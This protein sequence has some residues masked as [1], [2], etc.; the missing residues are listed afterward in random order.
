MADRPAHWSKRL[1]GLSPT[2]PEPSPR[3]HSSNSTSGFQP[4]AV[5]S[6]EIDPPVGVIDSK[7]RPGTS[8]ELERN[9]PVLSRVLFQSEDN[10][11]VEELCE[12]ISS[13]NYP[14]PPNYPVILL[15]I[16]TLNNKPSSPV[17]YRSFP[18]MTTI[19]S[20]ASTTSAMSIQ[21]LVSV[22]GGGTISIPFVTP[23]TAIFCSTSIPS[24]S[25]SSQAI[26]S[27]IGFFP[28]GMPTNAIPSVP[29]SIPSAT[30]TSMASGSNYFHGFP[31]RGGHIPHSNP[32]LGSC[33]FPLRVK[34]IICFKVGKTLRLVG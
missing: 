29:L 5:G 25:R 7:G 6:S 15:Y 23:S 10:I 19:G 12:S 17:L 33:L 30:S 32:T 18:S 14:I 27:S 3:R 13:P 1:H 28:F 11:E 20:M 2:S 34:V 9:T 4:M 31:F 22:Q 24:L 26:A 16:G 8:R 21:T